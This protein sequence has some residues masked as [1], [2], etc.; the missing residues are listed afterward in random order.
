M[1]E[2]EREEVRF[3]KPVARFLENPPLCVVGLFESAIS[4]IQ[5]PH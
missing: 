2:R 5:L 3:D 1:R 4:H